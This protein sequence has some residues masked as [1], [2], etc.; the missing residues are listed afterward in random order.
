M[1]LA[2]LVVWWSFDLILL[3]HGGLSHSPLYV[4]KGYGRLHLARALTH[5]G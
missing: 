5:L 3:A 2:E 1:F 4:S